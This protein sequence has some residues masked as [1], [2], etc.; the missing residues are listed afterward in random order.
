MTNKSK[1]KAS[2]V[3]LS[4]ERGVKTLLG[5]FNTV[6]FNQ[7]SI[8]NRLTALEEKLDVLIAMGGIQSQPQPPSGPKIV[9]PNFPQA[10][11][12]KYNFPPE[13][14]SALK[15]SAGQFDEGNGEK[16]DPG[17]N[18]EEEVFHKGARRGLRDP[19]KPS[20]QFDRTIVNQ[21]I[22]FSNGDALTYADITITNSSGKQIL[23]SRTNNKGKWSAPL[24]T[25]GYNV[26]VSKRMGKE[27]DKNVEITYEI[28]IPNVQTYDL[29]EVSIK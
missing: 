27:A 23:K 12:S 11:I 8:L 16:V 9:N 2:D 20:V 4:I 24:P 7:K 14:A 13:F 25:G 15:N 19:G 22:L 18:L 5:V 29:P 6:S 28:D 1:R 3:L 21:T 10:S 17:E 26:Y